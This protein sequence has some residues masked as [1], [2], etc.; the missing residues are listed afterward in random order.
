MHTVIFTLTEG[1]LQ[2][3]S[4]CSFLPFV[5]LLGCDS[6]NTLTKAAAPEVEKN[7]MKVYIRFNN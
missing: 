2:V 7:N 3:Q 4:S 6:L 1:D 5:L